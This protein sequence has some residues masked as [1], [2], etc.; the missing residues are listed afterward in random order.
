[1]MMNPD[2]PKRLGIL[3]VVSGPSGAGKTTLCRALSEADPNVEYSISC[4]TRRPRSGEVDGKDYQFLSRAEFLARIGAGDFLEHA[5]VHGHYYGTRR[6]SVVE[7]LERGV[8][9]VMDLDVE[10]AA[11]VR[12][13]QDATIAAARIDVFVRPHNRDEL[14]KRLAA[15]GTESRE[16]FE[17]RMNNAL[18]EIASWPLYQF[19]ILS[20]TREQDFA[21]FETIIKAERLRSSRLIER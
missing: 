5:A 4:T 1:M 8:D 20:G 3:C 12:S 13:I 16:Q 15:R 9:V 11:Q 2:D 18:N 6:S 19:Q 14:A 17:L 21:R 10:G 7:L